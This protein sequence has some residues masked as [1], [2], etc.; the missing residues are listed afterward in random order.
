MPRKSAPMTVIPSDF[1]LT[2]KTRAWIETKYPT[3]NIEATL[4]RFTD[5]A[6]QHGRM[7]ADWQAAARTW[8]RKAVENKWDG[9]EY[10]QG[11][12]QDPKWAPVMQRASGYG[13]RQPYSYETETS[14]ERELE[15]FVESKQRARPALTLVG[16]PL[17]RMVG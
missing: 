3:V 16:S 14:Y 4:E 7:Y 8:V 13:F 15:K 6:L 9:V 5:S 10:K 12:A 1:Q 17:K 2:E 11:K